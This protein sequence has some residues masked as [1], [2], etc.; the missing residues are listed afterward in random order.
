M[1]DLST[2][3][4]R[5]ASPGRILREIG[6]TLRTASWFP[7]IP[8]AAAVT[9][10]GAHLLW[11]TFGSTWGPLLTG[12][13]ATKEVRG[14]DVPYLLVGSSMMTMGVGLAF[15]S[16]VAWWI[17]FILTIYV[18]VFVFRFG[19]ANARYLTAFDSALAAA[20]LVSHRYFNRSILGGSAGFILVITPALV[21][22]SLGSFYL[23][24]QF[25][26]PITSLFG[27][28]YYAVVTMTTVGYGDITPRT[29]EARLFAIQIIF[30]G[31]GLLA[32]AITAVIGPLVRSSVARVGGGEGRR[33]V[34]TNHFVLIGATLLAQYVYQELVHRHLSVAVVV[35]EQPEGVFGAHDVVVGDPTDV[36]VLR[37][38]DVD[39][40]RAVAV[41][42]S[43]DFENA[44]IVLAL[45]ALRDPPKVFV[46]V[47]EVKHVA[48]IKLVH[49]DVIMT[50][51]VM[52]GELLAMAL[53]GET[54]TGDRL[55]ERLFNY[56]GSGGGDA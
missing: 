1:M 15:R 19:H 31:V 18:V 34:R 35:P 10:A 55:I 9:F 11:V 26:P 7:H 17:T 30:L 24:S 42:G 45:K 49:P 38:A 41:M 43:N 16:R 37:R 44:F 20:L 14:V 4:R 36:D 33:L 50:P 27:G 5:R 47:N 53:A 48:R 32:T 51:S 6:G 46:V 39:Q 52:S 21:Y 8:L 25:T 29:D 13:L 23:G 56:T 22:A 12:V 3:R 54:M 40:A 28:F 2:P